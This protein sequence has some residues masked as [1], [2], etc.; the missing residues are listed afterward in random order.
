MDLRMN[1]VDRAAGN[2]FTWLA[3]HATY[4]EWLETPSSLLWIKGKPGAGKSTLMKYVISDIEDGRTPTA[5]FF[6]N[7]RGSAIEKSPLGL[8]R[9]LLHQLLPI[10]DEQLSALTSVYRER[11]QT[12]GKYE[13]SWVWHEQELRDRLSHT[14]LA[15]AVHPLRVYVD[16]LDESGEE[17]ANQIVNYL[18][19]LVSKASKAG[20]FL[21]VCFSC[22]HYPLIAPKY[23]LE[24]LS[25]ERLSRILRSTFV[26]VWQKETWSQ[27]TPKS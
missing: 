23:G 7:G 16:A 8:Y 13:Q 11:C 6:F 24:V 9:S 10:A 15:L 4:Q 22:R 17:I 21:T 12:R 2:T 27:T 18:R 25:K 26:V 3:S 5:T 20:K 19:L 1:D 14:L